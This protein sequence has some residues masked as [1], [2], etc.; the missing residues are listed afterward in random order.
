MRDLSHDR[1]LLSINSM[2]VKAWSL[3]E[4]VEGCA[5]AGLSAISPWRDIV[6]ACGA[7]RAGKLIRAHDLTVTGLCRGGMFTAP[8]EA[9]RRTALDDNRRALDEAAEINAQ[10]LILVVG[11]L[12]KGS[13]DIGDAR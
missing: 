3:V 8:D 2:T 7:E 1:A 10:C 9:G 5:R 11:G 6:Q 13:R 4:L 12:A